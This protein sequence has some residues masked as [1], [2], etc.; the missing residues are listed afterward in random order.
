MENVNGKPLRITF[1]CPDKE[2]FVRV[3]KLRIALEAAEIATLWTTHDYE[4]K[5]I[6]AL[7]VYENANVV[8]GY[9]GALDS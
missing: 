8:A 1:Y 3:G 2:T 9:L 4:G 6:P 7:N 5:K